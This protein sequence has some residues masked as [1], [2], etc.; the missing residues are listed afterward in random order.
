MDS[1]GSGCPSHE[2]LVRTIRRVT[3]VRRILKL[4]GAMLAFAV[5]AWFAAVRLAP[6]AKRRRAAKRAGRV[7]S[8][9]R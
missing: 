9:G 7:R 1:R 3:L 6:E 4:L 8:P 2:P 5:Y